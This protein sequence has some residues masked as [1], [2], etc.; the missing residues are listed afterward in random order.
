MLLE[1]DHISVLIGVTSQKRKL[2]AANKLVVVWTPAKLYVRKVS[3][4]SSS[5]LVWGE[6]TID[7]CNVIC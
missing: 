4:Q 1:F 3:V 7:L 2:P 5:L 6:K